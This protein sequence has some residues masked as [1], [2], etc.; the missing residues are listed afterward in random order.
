MTALLAVPVGAAVLRAGWRWGHEAWCPEQGRDG[1]RK[2]SAQRRA[3]IEPKQ[4]KALSR[5][6]TGLKNPVP[7]AGCRAIVGKTRSGTQKLGPVQWAK[8]PCKRKRAEAKKAEASAGEK[9]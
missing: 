4:A 5:A 7:K 9:D 2:P 3:E 6:E 8:R 1:A